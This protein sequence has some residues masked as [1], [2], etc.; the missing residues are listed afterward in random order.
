MSTDDKKKRGFTLRK[1]DKSVEKTGNETGRLSADRESTSTTPKLSRSSV[2]SIV[3]PDVGLFRPDPT[4]TEEENARAKK[5]WEGERKLANAV[6]QLHMAKEKEM[7]ARQ[8][9]KE[10]DQK[11]EKSLV[12]DYLRR[13][14]KG[15]QRK[16][17]KNPQTSS[18]EEV[19]PIEGTSSALKPG[20][21]PRPGSAVRQGLADEYMQQYGALT[22]QNARKKKTVAEKQVNETSMKDSYLSKFLEDKL[23]APQPKPRRRSDADVIVIATEAP[24]D[25][26]V[27]KTPAPLRASQRES[28][29]RSSDRHSRRR[30]R[31]MSNK[32][33]SPGNKS[34]TSSATSLTKLKAQ[35][36]P[37]AASTESSDV[38]ESSST[39]EEEDIVPKKPVTKAVV[40]AAAAVPPPT[41]PPIV[42]VQNS[43]VSGATPVATSLPKKIVSEEDVKKALT[44]GNELGKG[45]FS[46]VYQA[47][48]TSDSTQVAVKVVDLTRL[49]KKQLAEL[50]A[51]RLILQDFH[52]PHVV[53]LLDIFETSSRLYL[54]LEL[55]AG[56]DLFNK[57]LSKGCFSERATKRI[58]LQVTQA[59]AAMHSLGIVHRD[60][61][62]ENIL[63][64]EDPKTKQIDVKVADFG[65]AKKIGRARAKSTCILEDH[66]ILTN[67]GFMDLD[68]WQQRCHENDLLVAGYDKATQQLVYQKPLAQYVLPHE[69]RSM[70]EF[71]SSC[72][73]VSY[74]VT[75]DHDVYVQPEA[76]Q[77][78]AFPFF[79]VP[80]LNVFKTPNVPFRHAGVAE[81]GMM[82]IAQETL[83]PQLNLCSSQRV[84]AFF[85]IYGFWLSSCASIVCDK[86]QAHVL[87]SRLP[88]AMYLSLL[89]ANAGVSENDFLV[90]GDCV[91]LL[92]G[93]WVSFFANELEH[94]L[95]KCAGDWI[96]NCASTKRAR[97]VLSGMFC[98]DGQDGCS[99][100]RCSSARLCDDVS[101]LALHAGLSSLAARCNSNNAFDVSLDCDPFPKSYG[102]N[103]RRV[104]MSGRV[105]C[106]TMP[107]GLFWVRR[108]H[109]ESPASRPVLTGN[110]GSPGYVAPE[111]IRGD[112]YDIS[113]DMFSLGAIV[114]V[115]LAGYPPFWGDDMKTIISKNLAVEYSFADM[116]WAHIAPSAK[117][118]IKNL[119]VLD[120]TA[121][122]TADQALKHD[123]LAGGKK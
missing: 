52:H 33:D 106:I 64:I 103:V 42:T 122:L 39:F 48:R 32:T 116:Y 43:D 59:V 67:K 70:I 111:V 119:L 92:S 60:L 61:K 75:D 44:L 17:A 96:W 82:N 10:K 94:S 49:T 58:V 47:L 81:N 101:R 62:P 18:E 50:D 41:A 12:S 19:K 108:P 16:K 2:G 102:T 4:K 7:T 3:A 72:S 5:E 57:I 80:A 36:A 8:A 45:A 97:L 118:F 93:A 69:T 86:G 40:A 76:Q 71:S 13:F 100:L 123:F 22:P 84:D 53:N 99:K 37:I 28:L 31:T 24:V 79:K 120:P 65:I 11:D 105:W 55:L 20:A 26:R 54:V 34:G 113:V 29:T 46:L 104:V 95:C 14:T 88:D 114:Y 66:E 63:C 78:R 21:Q 27:S 23:D 15:L 6:A 83:P 91:A 85:E 68:T 56:G 90:L 74:V 109:A 73:D 1:K 77:D 117:D 87:F 110:C 121:R 25:D 38:E 98:V 107:C 89:L 115:L 51:E 35:A 112:E 30:S 9:E